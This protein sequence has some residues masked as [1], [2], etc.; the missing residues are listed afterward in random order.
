MNMSNS[1]ITVK[2]VARRA[3]PRLM[4]NLVFP[5][6]VYRDFSNEFV[7]GKG[8]KVQIRKPVVLTASDFD[9]TSGTSPESVNESTVD[10][11]LDRLA[12]VDV[13]FGALESAT[14]IDSLE[15]LFI[16]PAAAAL[17]EKI[18][19]DG[20]LLY[21]EVANHTGTPGTT[22]GTLAAIAAA[23]K[24]LNE[25]KAPLS[26]RCAVWDPAANAAFQQLPALV[27]AEK[28]GSTRALREGAIGRV[29]G[30]DHY[31][32]QGV[33]QITSS[34]LSAGGTSAT[35][36]VVKTSVSAK[37]KITLVS[38]GTASATLTG[39]LK[40]GDILVL[41]GKSFTVAE[42]CT[43]DDDEITVTLNGTVTASAGDSVQTVCGGTQNL[44]FHK[45]AFAFVT[46]PLC[47]PAGVESYTTGYNGITLR[48]CRGYDMKHKKDM[49][50]MD[51]LYGYKAVY[52][53]LAVRVLG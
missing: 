41:G 18:N 53:E 3:L 14:D 44:M 16:A 32:A 22:P 9:E 20:L 36:P 52:P 34:G 51:V 15:R 37:N 2:E 4:E 39:S 29:F 35:G 17:A 30:V 8:A 45:N 47:A 21:S 5:S 12:T 49:L 6:L 10:V 33:K 28:S 25:N 27:N 13:E 19:A 43:A 24:V 50:S 23:A 38:N 46:R 1:L 40:K 42:N 7:P 48:V 26:D 31:M 11:E